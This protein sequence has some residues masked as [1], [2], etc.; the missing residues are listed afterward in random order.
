MWSETR[1]VGGCLG[2]LAVA[3]HSTKAAVLVS[4][5]V[6]QPFQSAISRPTSA[7]S[8]AWLPSGPARCVARLASPPPHLPPPSQVI[9]MGGGFA[10]NLATTKL[11]GEAA[12]PASPQVPDVQQW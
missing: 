7:A 6:P 4:C 10:L 5:L 1:A 12:E 9:G 2:L 11:S 8:S 3:C